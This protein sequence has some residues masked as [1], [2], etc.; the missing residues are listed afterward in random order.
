MEFCPTPPAQLRSTC[1]T[2]QTASMPSPAGLLGIWALQGA[3]FTPHR[4]QHGGTLCLTPLLQLLQQA[5]SNGLQTST[6]MCS[7]SSASQHCIRYLGK[8][9]GCLGEHS[10]LHFQCRA[11]CWTESSKA[12]IHQ[13]GWLLGATTER[14]P[15][16]RKP[17]LTQ[18]LH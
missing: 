2:E 5:L 3:Q 10:V 17:A 6:C 13:A 14:S 8:W 18:R 11:I 15:V 4:A 1:H 12:S 7:S 9:T 16:G